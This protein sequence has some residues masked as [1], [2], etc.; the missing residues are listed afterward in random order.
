MKSLFSEQVTEQ[1]KRLLDCFQYQSCS[2]K[3]L[4][5]KLSLHHRPT[6]LD[7]YL[8]PGIETGLVEMTQPNSP[9]SPTHKYQLTKKGEKT[10]EE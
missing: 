8:N 7:N 3:D 5:F 6:F 4:M 2:V 1:V 10:I 9:K